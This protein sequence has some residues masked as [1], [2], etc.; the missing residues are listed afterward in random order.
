MY[1]PSVWSLDYILL[2]FL[3]YFFP[4]ILQLFRHD[5]SWR[6]CQPDFLPLACWKFGTHIF[7]LAVL[8]LHLQRF[9]LEVQFTQSLFGR[10]FKSLLLIIFWI[11]FVGWNLLQIFI[12]YISPVAN[13]FWLVC[14]TVSKNWL[15]TI[16]C[17]VLF[18][19]ELFHLVLN[20]LFLYFF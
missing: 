18:S 7:Y 12:S 14:L 15:L 4:I 1:A 10:P 3:T 20:C 11:S 9:A 19:D 17:C 8:L 13:V 5:L 6:S 16:F 2:Y